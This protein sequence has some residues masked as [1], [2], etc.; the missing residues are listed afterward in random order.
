MMKA[1]VPFGLGPCAAVLFALGANEQPRGKEEGLTLFARMMPVFAHARCANCH[2]L[3]DP[4]QDTHP[5]GKIPDVV[6][7]SAGMLESNDQCLACHTEKTFRVPMPP[8]EKG[9][10]DTEESAELPEASRWRLPPT[11]MHFAGKS[12]MKVCE[13]MQAFVEEN[14]KAEAGV[15]AHLTNDPL[16]AWA[17]EGRAAGARDPDP[18]SPPGM[19]HH[20][21]VSAF[22]A[23]MRDGASCDPPAV[24]TG[25]VTI[26]YTTDQP[27]KTEDFAGGGQQVREITKARGNRRFDIEVHA[28]TGFAAVSGVEMDDYIRQ[29]LNLSNGRCGFG[30]TVTRTSIRSYNNSRE[31]VKL[32]FVPQPGVPKGVVLTF[33]MPPYLTETTNDINYKNPSCG[34][35]AS[36]DVKTRTD[37]VSNATNNMQ[38]VDTMTEIAGLDGK[39]LMLVLQGEN[40][41]K[42]GSHGL[43]ITWDLVKRPAK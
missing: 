36:H 18:A 2:G 39:P 21:F 4:T 34:L 23:W 43:V 27:E 13:Q 40:K 32:K 16:I 12:T 15:L 29:N 33:A 41:T 26:E 9:S 1:I 42:V 3:V 11:S 6:I 35:K 24:W 7:T 10:E 38:I 20:A 31:R 25:T 5:G 37:T 8:N 28:D 17:F 19:S 14:G 30:E 22:M